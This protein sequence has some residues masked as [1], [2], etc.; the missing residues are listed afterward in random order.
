MWV[1][2]APFLG[3]SLGSAFAGCLAGFVVAALQLDTYPP[4]DE[5]AR[6]LRLLIERL[7]LP[8]RTR[9]DRLGQR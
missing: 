5:R 8:W 2:V 9:V 7:R 1:I 4:D 3:G 6:E